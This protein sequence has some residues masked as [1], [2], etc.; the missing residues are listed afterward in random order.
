ML[1]VFTDLYQHLHKVVAGVGVEPTGDLAYETGLAP[2]LR[3][4][5]TGMG[6]GN[7][8]LTAR[9]WNPAG[10]SRAHPYK[11]G[12]PGGERTHTISSF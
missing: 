1:A 9:V 4:N 5:E 3:R 10:T 8:N 7:R 11:I 6:V 12:V 2:R